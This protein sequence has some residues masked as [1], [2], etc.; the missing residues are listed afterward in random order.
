MLGADEFGIATAALISAGCIMMR[1]CHLNTCP[2]GVAT[3]DPQLRKRFTGK[4]E[5][6]INYFTFVAEEAREIM[7]DLGFRS[8][9]EMIGRMDRLDTRGAVEHWKVQGLD[10]SRIFDKPKA[11]PD[12]AVFNCEQQ[13]HGLD[14]ALDN[15]LI[16]QAMLALENATPVSIEM[17]VKNVNRS[18]GAMLSGE[19]ARRYGHAGLADDTIHVSMTGTAGQ[20]F[21]A[22]L[23]RGVTLDLKGDANDYV[24]KGLSGGCIIVRPA[25]ES[26][27]V[28]EDNIIIG[29]T[30]LYGAT[31]GECF[32]RGVA[33]ERFVG[34]VNFRFQDRVR[35]KRRDE[36]T[37]QLIGG[38]AD[39]IG[40]GVV[41]VDH[42]DLI[43]IVALQIAR[44]GKFGHGVHSAAAG[45]S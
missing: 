25:S 33:G 1:K 42:D 43:A 12:V 15:Q 37:G 19:I 23:A 5:D 24:G 39:D 41:L 16:E 32:F 29:N 44:D 30:V 38:F 11:G 40:H 22:W 13:D 6:V 21:G 4:P 45:R 2:T 14:K 9:N 28:P 31:A 8:M 3:Q 7:A 34:A 20:S 18:V 17:P 27:L 26:S 36:N 10:L 35:R